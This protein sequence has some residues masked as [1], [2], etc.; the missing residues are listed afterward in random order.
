MGRCLARAETTRTSRSVGA[1]VAS[2]TIRDRY[3]VELVGEGVRLREV[4]SEDAAAALA[5]AADPEYFL[6]LPFEPITDEAAE[7]LFLAGLAA[8]AIEQPRR[9]YHL[10]IVWTATNELIGM[11]RLGISEPEH[12]VGDIGYGVRRDRNGEGIATEAAGLLLDLG[13]ADLGLHRIFA[14]HHPAN[15]GSQRVLEKLGMQ[16][17]GRLRENLLAHGAW[18]DS[19]VWGILDREWNQ[20]RSA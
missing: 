9:Q 19:V 8:Q 4:S 16:R 10:G 5:F 14:Y 3:P 13:F 11:A 20:V 17:E 15:V 12:L 7:S 6:Y 2:V 18:R 1:T